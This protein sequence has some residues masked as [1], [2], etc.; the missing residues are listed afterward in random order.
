[1]FDALLRFTD[2]DAARA[3]LPFPDALDEEGNA[4]PLPGSWTIG[5]LSMMPARYIIVKAVYTQ[6]LLTDE[7]V[8]VTPELTMDGYQIVVRASTRQTQLEDPTYCLAVVR[9]DLASQGLPFIYYINPYKTWDDINTLLAVEPTFAGSEYTFPG[10][11]SDSDM[12]SDDDLITT[13]VD[14]DTSL[15]DTSGDTD[16]SNSGDVTVVGGG[17]NEASAVTDA[18]SL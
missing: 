8:L 2:E 15:D 14:T 18:E 12:T 7:S 9:Y 5:E 3:V 17:T 1:M 6:D 16:T 11:L 4:L 13:D 10:T